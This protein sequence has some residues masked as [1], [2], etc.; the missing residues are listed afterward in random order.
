MGFLKLD[1]ASA[2][3]SRQYTG[4]AGKVTN[5]QAGTPLV[6]MIDET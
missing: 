3:G 6:N 1:D 2:C 4:T 5:Y